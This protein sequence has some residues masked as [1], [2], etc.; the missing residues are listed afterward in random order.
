MFTHFLDDNVIKLNEELIK[1]FKNYGF[2]DI[3]YGNDCCNS[4][5]YY[6]DENNFF[7]IFLPNS[8]LDNI[9]NEQFN[10]FSLNIQNS[11]HYIIF[12]LYDIFDNIED[13]LGFIES[14]KNIKL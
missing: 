2:N 6:I 13:V 14:N 9:D 4:V 5:V 7:Q 10:K 8:L 3:S 11:I 1:I 12:E